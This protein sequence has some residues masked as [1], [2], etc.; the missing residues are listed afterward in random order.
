LVLQQPL[1]VGGLALAS[2]LA[3]A[4]LA[5]VTFVASN[6]ILAVV[7]GIGLTGG[8][9][10]EPEGATGSPDAVQGLLVSAEPEADDAVDGRACRRRAE[11]MTHRDGRHD[12]CAE[13]SGSAGAARP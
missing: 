9:V 2:A 3:T 4:T 1:R 10:A 13:R 6:L 11:R 7:A 8:V 12:R 5:V